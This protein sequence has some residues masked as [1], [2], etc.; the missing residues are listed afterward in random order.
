MDKKDDI[1]EEYEIP[2]KWKV[3]MVLDTKHSGDLSKHQSHIVID[4]NPSPKGIPK[5]HATT[6]THLI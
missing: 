5:H 4:N 3:L 1:L 6:T 2:S